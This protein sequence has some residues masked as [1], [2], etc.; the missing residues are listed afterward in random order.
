MVGETGG[1]EIEVVGTQP[2]NMG[3]ILGVS[4]AALTSGTVGH[5][6]VPLIGGGKE[7][8][9]AGISGGSRGGSRGGK[10]KRL[11]G[12]TIDR[13]VGEGGRGRMEGSGMVR[14]TTRGDNTSGRG[15][16][17]GSQIVEGMRGR[18]G[19]RGEGRGRRGG[20]RTRQGMEGRRSG[21]GSRTTGSLDTELRLRDS[22]LPLGG[23]SH[24][25]LNPPIAAGEPGLLVGVHILISV[26]APDVGIPLRLVTIDLMSARA[27]VEGLFLPRLEDAVV[28]PTPAIVERANVGLAPLVDPRIASCVHL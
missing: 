5:V 23:A 20:G 3:T 2:V 15:R 27:L 14:E 18:G 7:L 26:L 9:E 25:V 28:M 21:R 12:R 6:T 19:R 11:S 13:E 4:N 8:E 24:H 17:G 1:A 10:G 16:G 22:R